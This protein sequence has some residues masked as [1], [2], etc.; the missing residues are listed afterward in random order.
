M[1]RTVEGWGLAQ[2]LRG[3]AAPGRQLSRDGHSNERTPSR[4]YQSSE[5]DVVARFGRPVRNSRP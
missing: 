4:D 3:R 1:N 5:A 2:G